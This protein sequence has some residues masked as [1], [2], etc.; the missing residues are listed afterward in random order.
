MSAAAD[1]HIAWGG[2]E[3]VEAVSALPAA[4]DCQTVIL[5]P[6]MSL[7][8]VDPELLTDRVL[9]RLVSDVAYFD[10]QACSSPQWV[11]VKSMHGP[12]GLDAVVQ[13][14]AD[15][16]AGQ[17]RMLP[18]HA[19]DAGETYRIALDRTRVLLEGGVLHR[20]EET[21]WTVAVLDTP[22]PRVACA[23]RFVQIVPFGDVDEI[24]PF[25]PGNAQTVVM[26]LG[27]GDAERFSES[28]ARRGVHRFARPGEGN[29]FESPWDG[30]PLFSR[31]TRWTIR[32]E[33]AQGAETTSR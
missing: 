13:R 28:A 11:F 29:H 16:L 8:V 33:A 2:R 19:L 12:A 7:A 6:R 26:L 15:A 25:I 10:Q 9:T 21:A 31:M 27:A 23:N 4:W 32:S 20:D 3:A 24:G 14:F 5:G 1:V 22:D 17:T 18:R 30:I